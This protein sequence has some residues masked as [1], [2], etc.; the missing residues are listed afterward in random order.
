MGVVV[1]QVPVARESQEDFLRTLSPAERERWSGCCARPVLDANDAARRAGA[2]THPH[3]R[4][5]RCGI[6][7]RHRGRLT[8]VTGPA[9]ATARRPGYGDSTR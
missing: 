1:R 6:E 7:T 9:A 5:R 2:A 8:G 3:R 4:C